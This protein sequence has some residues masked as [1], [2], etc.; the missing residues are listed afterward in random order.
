LSVASALP[1]A[2]LDALRAQLGD[3]LQI[4]AATA[5]GGGSVAQVLRLDTDAGG[6]CLPYCL[7]LGPATHPFD[8]EAAGLAALAAAQALR[9]PQPIAHGRAGTHGYLLLEWIELYEQGD[10]RAAGSALAALHAHSAAEHGA[11]CANTIGATAQINTP[12]AHW[13]R[14]WR[15]CRLRPQFALARHNGLAALAAL[16]EEACAASDALLAAHFPPPALLHGDLWRGNLA[17]DAQG[18]PV[19]V[20][21]ACY[22]GDA[23]TDLAMTRLFGGFPPLFYAAYAAARPPATGA[24]ERAALYR[25]YHV[26]N[27][28]NLFGGGYTAQ[29]R[30]LIGQVAAY[31]RRY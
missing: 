22:Y 25:L 16:E 15:E 29:A 1:A 12:D 10:W 2:V 14:F 26:L 7:K 18:A 24:H 8:A 21:P 9:V 13:A 27:H 23:E 5:V 4:R 30:A 17:F 11:A 6:H 20:D 31:S 28:A 19:L 3:R